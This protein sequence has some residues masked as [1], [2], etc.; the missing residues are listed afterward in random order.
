ML[1]TPVSYTHLDVYKRQTFTYPWPSEKAIE[2][3]LEIL[4]GKE[5]DKYIELETVL[6]TAENVD[7]YY[8]PDS[9]Y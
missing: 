6:I 2:T 3:A 4:N 7:E 9:D 1:R 8:D 5:V